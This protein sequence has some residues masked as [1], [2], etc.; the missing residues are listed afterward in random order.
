MYRTVDDPDF[1][2]SLLLS[3]AAQGPCLEAR[4]LAG[5]RLGGVDGQRFEIV[6]E[7]CAGSMSVVYRARDRL[8]E[9]VTAIKLMLCRR[10]L[11]QEDAVALFH[12]EARAVAR[13][14]HQNI[15]KIFDVG[16][17]SA[18]P[19]LVMEHLPGEPLSA[20]LRHG[21]LGWDTAA[22]ILIQIAGD[23]AHAHEHGLIHRDLKPSNV[24]VLPDGAIKVID[25]GLARS[26]LD[27]RGGGS[28]ALAK[29]GTPPYMAPE[30]WLGGPQ[31]A[32]TDVWAMGVVLFEMLAGRRPYPAADLAA[33]EARVTS[34]APAP[35]LREHCP[36]LPARAEEIVAR[37][38]Q[39]DPGR[40]FQAAHE[41]QRA[42]IP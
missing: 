5:D 3:V 25:F 11:R 6:E 8:L 4:P 29:A 41:M 34:P 21:R 19:F 26:I 2:D 14:D 22:R 40:R 30:Q 38:L 33:L 32:R 18:T 37:A 9:R 42:L 10:G 39:K 36:D 31:D 12:G 16:T 20:L 15:V 35:P 23:L 13:L 1:G 24:F 28:C 7:I 17:W 27:A